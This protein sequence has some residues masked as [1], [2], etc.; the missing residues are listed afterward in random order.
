MAT[1]VSSTAM[2]PAQIDYKLRPVSAPRYKMMRV[3]MNNLPSAT[4]IVQPTASTVLE[5]KLPNVVYNLARSYISYSVSV[6]AVA[7]S[8]GV[9]FE[10][11]FDLGSSITFGSAG[12]VDLVN[13][14]YANNYSKVARKLNTPLDDFLGNDDMSGLYKSNATAA[15]N[16]VPGGNGGVFTPNVNYLENAYMRVSGA[17]AAPAA[18]TPLISYRQY[19]LGAFSGTLLGVDR[20]FFSPV[21]Q[22]LRVS[23]GTGDKTAFSYTTAGANPS[24]GAASI[25]AGVTFNNIYLYLCVE[26]N[27]DIVDGL[28]AEYNANKLAYRI[29]YTTS[30]KNVGGSANAVTNI[31]IQLS[32]Q[33]GRRLKRIIHTVWNPQEKFNTAYDIDNTNGLKVR[34]FQTS[35]DSMNIQD[36][37]LSC[38]VPA[39]GVM[40]MDDWA[41]NRKFLDK[42]S[43]I[44]SKEMCQLNWFHMDQFFEP[45]SVI[46][47]ELASLPEVNIDEGLPM[48][49]ARQWI[50]SCTAGA[51]AG[52]IHYT[53][54]EF[55][56]EILIT[57]AGPIWV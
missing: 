3:P 9:T 30:F 32:Q 21:E 8:S 51:T 36:R 33:Y 53:F 23:A 14:Q 57:N 29:P 16:I 47:G 28:I 52:L 31:S 46:G 4:A 12:G 10:D 49:T 13:L 43:I 44:L 17:P 25:A 19:P 27:Q 7:S 26:K 54:A 35:M 5:W 38:L 37:V 11:V 24:I 48:P 1:S 55:A 34:D 50:F 40:N 56:R 6:P 18:N 20:D 42:R 22:Y 15:A 41:E 2:T 45:H 39:N